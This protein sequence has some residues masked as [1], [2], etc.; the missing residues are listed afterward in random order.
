MGKR[1]TSHNTHTCFLEH[2]HYCR[3]TH[4]HLVRRFLSTLGCWLGLQLLALLGWS[5][6]DL[7][8]VKLVHQLHGE[9]GQM[10]PLRIYRHE[11]SR[12]YWS[13]RGG[14]HSINTGGTSITRA[15]DG[16]ICI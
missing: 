8:R 10:G 2:A 9:R 15:F 16:Y 5:P 14:G 7:G 11:K 13:V 1:W 3:Y 6:L 4:T 12:G